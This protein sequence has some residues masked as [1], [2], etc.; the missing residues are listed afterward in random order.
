MS[1]L[2]YYIIIIVFGVTPIAVIFLRFILKK[3]I[4]FKISVI[5]A[6]LLD[7]ISILSFIVG[8]GGSL[9]LL[10]IAGPIGIGI[11]IGGFVII[12]KL[13]QKFDIL[14]KQL[15]TVAKGNITQDINEKL[16]IRNDEIGIIAQGVSFLGIK[17]N[18][19]I[20]K[21]KSNTDDLVKT[22]SN[23]LD[24]SQSIS[25]MSNEQASSTEE[26]ASTI[27]EITANIEQNTDSATQTEQVSIKL[28]ESIEKVNEKSQKSIKATRVIAEK[29][30]IINDIAFQ[31]N[32]LALNAAVE[33]ARAGEHGKG[34]AVVASEVRK[35]AQNSKTAADEIV[36][37]ANNTLQMV[38]SAGIQLSEMLPEVIKTVSL[39]Q[40]ISGSSMEQAASINQINSAI[41]QLN[42]SSQNNTVMADQLYSISQKLEEQAKIME[43]LISYFK[44][45][46]NHSFDQVKVQL[47]KN[48]IS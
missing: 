30:K 2:L 41:Q 29:I 22:S 46:N 21:I 12:I 6:V 40:E 7:S 8:T 32:I 39:V 18:E 47:E 31:T 43:Q 25:Q 42:N 15:N 11:V 24:T 35:L 1:F 48:Y 44:L 3:S 19:I 10:L 4:A 9:S 26:I 38:E 27:E 13:L 33:A 5:V 14:S 37:L 34:F 36:E 28:K 23:I 17:L 20:L 16:V 45:K